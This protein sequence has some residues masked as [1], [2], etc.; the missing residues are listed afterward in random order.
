MIPH[1]PCELEVGESG[2]ERERVL[3]QPLVER[4]VERRSELRPLR[5]VQVGVDESGHD[6]GVVGEHDVGVGV[7]ARRADPVDPAHGVDLDRL[8]DEH[9]EP[10]G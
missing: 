4:E 3:E 5:G 7:G 1:L 10:V 6:H 9:V 2:F 8:V